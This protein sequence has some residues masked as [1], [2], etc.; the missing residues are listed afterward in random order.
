MDED[1]WLQMLKDR[2]DFIY[3]HDDME[4]EEYANRIK[5]I[6]IPE[7]RKMTKEIEKRYQDLL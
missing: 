6:Y 3:L 7:F 5:E 2:N 4:L 1:S